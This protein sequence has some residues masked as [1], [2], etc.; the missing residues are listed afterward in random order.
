M[1]SPFFGV[2]NLTFWMDNNGGPGSTRDR[3]LGAGIVWNSAC[4][5][6]GA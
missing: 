2:G 3:V 5:T 4:G 1:G 6:C